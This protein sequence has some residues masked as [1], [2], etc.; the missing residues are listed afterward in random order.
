MLLYSKTSKKASDVIAE[1]GIILKD[2]TNDIWPETEKLTA[3]KQALRKMYPDI[4]IPK[5]DSATLV[6]DGVSLSY[7]I[8]AGFDL[9]L[10]AEAKQT[11]D[12]GWQGIQ[13][14][15]EWDGT[16]NKIIFNEL[17]I[18][19][20]L[21][22]IRGGSRIA[23]PTAVSSDLDISVDTEDL[24]ISAAKIELIETLLL[25]KT[26]L[27]QFAAREQG[28]TEVDVLNMLQAMRREYTSRKG[29]ISTTLIAQVTRV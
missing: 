5:V 15:I 22:K 20:V 18:A 29:E 27:N 26:K 4:F 1:L 12:Y 21:F 19:G 9:V 7:N 13:Y 16:N 2:T 28:V 8:P 11:G 6:A 14:N 24:L 23:V 25:D 10:A 17:Y 3:I